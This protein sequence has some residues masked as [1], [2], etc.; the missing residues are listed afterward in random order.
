MRVKVFCAGC[1]SESDVE[2]EMDTNYYQ[3]NYCTFCGDEIDDDSSE[4]IDE[5]EERF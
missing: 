4:V 5:H 2:H 3:I 1:K